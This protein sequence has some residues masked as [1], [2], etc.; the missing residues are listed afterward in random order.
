MITEP[1]QLEAR[2]SCLDVLCRNIVGMHDGQV[3]WCP[4]DAPPSRAETL[5]WLWFIRPDL[6]PQIMPLAGQE[7]QA[8]MDCYRR[9]DLAAWW[10]RFAIETTLPCGEDQVV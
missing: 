10:G 8:L 4:N 1:D 9:N 3:R 7:L 6:A 2:R 5:A